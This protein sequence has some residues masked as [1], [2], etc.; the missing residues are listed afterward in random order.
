MIYS[1][2]LI[3]AGISQDSP[4]HSSD[5]QAADLRASLLEFN[6]QLI[7]SSSEIK[8]QHVSLLVCLYRY[9]R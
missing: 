6:F 8:R 1:A 3:A 9:A 2:F 7:G 4:Q 5:H